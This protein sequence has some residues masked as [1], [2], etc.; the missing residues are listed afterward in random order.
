MSASDKIIPTHGADITVRLLLDGHGFERTARSI[1]RAV[2][3]GV[4]AV[5]VSFD[6]PKTIVL[7]AELAEDGVG[8]A[9]LRFNGM[10][11]SKGERI[12]MSDK[13]SGVV[14][15]MAVDGAIIDLL[16]E[17]FESVVY[18]SPLLETPA[19]DKRFVRLFLTCANAY[20][21][22]W[23]KGL[24][25]AEVV[26]DQSAD[27][28]LYCLHGLGREFRLHRFEIHVGGEGA[29]AVA[30]AVSQYFKHVKQF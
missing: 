27:S 14:A 3:Q 7:P 28:A 11:L 26:P 23:D 6:T 9:Y 17:S 22:V 18:S 30:V 2:S 19:A 24:K 12:A 1:G 8:E 15:L 10:E 13:D 20:L 5:V 16:E 29:S 4:R 25:F 21:T